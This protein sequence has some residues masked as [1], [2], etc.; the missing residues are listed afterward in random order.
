MPAPK[1]PDN[2]PIAIGKITGT[3]A[4]RGEVKLHLFNERSQS[5]DVGTKV[6]LQNHP[7]DGPLEIK[8]LRPHKRNLLVRFAGHE[9]VEAAEKLI[10]A[11]V[12]VPR[13]QLPAL[14]ESEV[15]HFQLIGMRVSTDQG[16][17]LGTVREVLDLPA[18]DVC[19]VRKGNREVLIPFI[20]DVIERV[21]VADNHLTV[22]PLS[23]LLDEE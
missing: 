6:L 17:D 19:V 9:T 21:D 7:A 22:R 13:E 18:N 5:L 15:Y 3:H 20:D 4:L 14:A 12:C 1:A 23:G 16:V 2:L 8:T 10:G 11:E